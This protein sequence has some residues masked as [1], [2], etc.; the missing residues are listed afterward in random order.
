MQLS[1]QR[2]TSTGNYVPEIDGLRF[3]AIFSVVLHHLHGFFKSKLELQP[4]SA[5]SS[6][7]DHIISNGH[8]G[9]PLFF[10]ISGYILGMPF[11][12][13]YLMR[14]KEIPLRS[15][16]MRRLTRLEPP[17][18]ITMTLLMLALVFITH[19]INPEEGLFSYM[20][21]LLYVHGFVFPGEFPKLNGVAWSLEIEVQFYI[22]APVLAFL[23]FRIKNSLSRRTILF[24]LM[25]CFVCYQH[26]NNFQVRSLLNY[27]HWF[28]AGFLLADLKLNN[29]RLFQAAFP[30]WL[31]GTPLLVGFFSFDT[32][33]FTDS[34]TRI[35]WEFFQVASVVFLF[36]LI[37][38]NGIFS[39]LKWK[40]ISYIG[41]MCYSIYL[42][43][44]PLIS[45]LGNAMLSLKPGITPAYQS[46]L[47][48]FIL[49][50]LIGIIS[51]TFFL[52]IER[53]CM[54]KNWFQKL[55]RKLH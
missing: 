10:T 16:F 30:G 44:Y 9:V 38:Q 50:I 4:A 24:I 31:I 7:L 18:I 22:L 53:P 20:C 42:L 11:A 12:N 36:H 5:V 25:I 37:L 55:F 27:F 8:L 2:I 47:F 21:S 49:L 3:I 48:S 54:D 40:S 51:A 41:G 26:L 23:I 17:Y 32:A 28:L 35:C 34:I 19:K 15:Y 45:I 46:L 43:H 29:F 39:F 6:V 14:G 52:F 13:H 1:F 33:F